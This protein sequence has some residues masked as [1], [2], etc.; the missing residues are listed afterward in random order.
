VSDLRVGTV[1][2]HGTAEPAAAVGLE[3]GLPRPELVMARAAGENFSVASYLFG[4]RTRRHL[5]AIYGFARLVDE[6]GDAA[7][8]DRLALLDAV[9]RELDRV[10]A[11]EPTHPLL[12]ALV[13]TV[14]GLELPREPFLRLIAANRQDQLVT[15]YASFEDLRAY[16]S[17]SA[18]P[19]GELVLRVF[20]RATPERV[21]QS[22]RVC[23]GLQVVEH[24][25][26]VGEDYAQGRIYLPLEDLARFGVDETDLDT[27]RVSEPLRALLAFESTR[28]RSLLEAGD[29]LIRSLRGRARVAVAAYVGGGRA[30]LRALDEAQ[31]EV[32]ANTPRPSRARRALETLG[33]LA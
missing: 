12:R 18:D 19:V 5:R 25:Q 23:T 16:C 32:L 28:A 1:A 14:R 2:P 4:A 22:D 17:L 8:G 31:Y 29:L 15:R 10:F 27:P 7:V 13:P 33:A 11:G 9:E 26:D 20:G 24:L 21:A 3:H 6:I 30:A